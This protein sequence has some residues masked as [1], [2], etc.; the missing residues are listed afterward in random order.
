[1][2]KNQSVPM[3]PNFVN[4]EVV[5]N[6]TRRTQLTDKVYLLS[7]FIEQLLLANNEFF[8]IHSFLAEDIHFAPS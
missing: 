8:F 1:M 3:N 4:F 6:T 7:H 5:L 2:Q